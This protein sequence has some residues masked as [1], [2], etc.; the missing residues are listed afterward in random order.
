[1]TT[2][3]GVMG[4]MIVVAVIVFIALQYIT[5]PYGMAFSRK[6]GPSMPNKLGWVLM[7]V[8][9]II[10]SL[11]IW[12]TSPRAGDV[13]PAVM[14]SL[15]MLHYVQRTFVFPFLMRGKSRISLLVVLMGMAF[16]SVNAY[17]IAGWLFRVAP[18]GLYTASWLTSPLFILG[19]V[20]FFVGMFI[21]LQSDY[22]V[23]HLRKP[24]DTKHYI[25]RGGLFRYVTSANYFGELTEWVGFAI[26]T[27]SMAGL[28]FVIWTFANL[29]PR[30]KSLYRRYCDEFGDEYR[31][32]GRKYII[33]FIY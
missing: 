5:A 28:T 17:L 24:G 20:I 4:V 12:L 27:W 32:L 30:A 8:P 7:E 11:L 15:M 6:W 23:R 33:P 3:Y 9:V 2:Y 14:M 19:T 22:I 13:A 1:M 31:K 29:A 16:N 26:L 21:N 10:V 25:P 18:E